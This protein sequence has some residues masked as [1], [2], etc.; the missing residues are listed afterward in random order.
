MALFRNNETTTMC[1][2]LLE[3]FPTIQDFLEHKSDIIFYIQEAFPEEDKLL[4]RSTRLKQ[5]SPKEMIVRKNALKQKV[6]RKFIA[7][8][9]LVY[10]I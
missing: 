3:D 4:V 6:E 9:K 1:S 5:G 10:H 2:L 7:L 8:R